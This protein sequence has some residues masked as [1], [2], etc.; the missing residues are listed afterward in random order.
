M[1]I[2]LLGAESTGKTRMAAL[3]A[4]HLGP[5][6][7]SVRVVEAGEL[8]SGSLHWQQSF[9]VTLLLALDTQ[10][11]PAN[12]LRSADPYALVQ[13][14][15]SIRK[16]LSGVGVPYR[17]IY[18]QGPERLA[19]AIAAIG[20]PAANRCPPAA[21]SPRWQWSCEKCGDPQCE[22]RLFSGVRDQRT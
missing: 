6:A 8:V 17:V 14:D 11:P 9:D 18:G 19:N 4:A 16:A 22:H 12:G 13:A 15:A 10:G 3:M 21:A 1:K 7:G 2:A 5:H 20:L